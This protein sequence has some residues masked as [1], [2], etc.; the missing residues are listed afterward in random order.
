MNE[1]KYFLKLKNNEKILCEK[2]EFDKY[3]HHTNGDFVNVKTPKG[4]IYIMKHNILLAGEI[5]EEEENY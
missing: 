1:K 4:N 3:I 2:E 5:E